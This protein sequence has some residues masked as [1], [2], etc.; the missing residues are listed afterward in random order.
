MRK[1]DKRK[2]KRCVCV[3]YCVV[4]T[5]TTR[6]HTVPS[7]HRLQKPLEPPHR[8]RSPHY[9]LAPDYQGPPA[10]NP[11]S[12]TAAFGRETSLTIADWQTLTRKH[13]N[14]KSKRLQYLILVSE[15]LVQDL[16]SLSLRRHRVH[17]GCNR[18]N[19]TQHTRT[20]P[21]MWPDP[22]KRS[23][24]TVSPQYNQ[25]SSTRTLIISS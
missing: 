11:C 4:C 17:A 15:V 6:S 21:A 12:Y 23:V 20:N 9:T 22:N 14:I 13:N 1:E 25:L 7:L 2:K 3:C 24:N 10:Q 18:Y 19:T 8:N 16:P 5:H